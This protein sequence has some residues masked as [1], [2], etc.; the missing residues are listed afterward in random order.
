MLHS[1][2]NIVLIYLMRVRSMLQTSRDK[3]ITYYYLNRDVT[4]QTPSRI[5]YPRSVFQSCRHQMDSS[6]TY[7]LI[8]GAV[9]CVLASRL[10]SQLH[11]S[12]W[13]DHLEEL[14]HRQHTP[15]KYN[16]NTGLYKNTMFTTFVSFFILGLGV[17][18]GNKTNVQ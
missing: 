13:K 6:L 15:W 9:G 16:Y 7:L 1:R 17:I 12:T 3:L 4:C 14:V 10:V 8:E 18:W 5:Y 11:F 2:D